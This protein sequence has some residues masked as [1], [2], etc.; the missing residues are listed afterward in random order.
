MPFRPVEFDGTS[1]LPYVNANGRLAY[2]VRATTVRA[3][4]SGPRV[5][6]PERAERPSAAA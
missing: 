5:E 4:A 2:S 6:R 1:V 3:P